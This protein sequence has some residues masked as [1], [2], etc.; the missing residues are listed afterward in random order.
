MKKTN[1]EY[2]NLE[3]PTEKENKNKVNKSCLDIYISLI[4]ESQII[5]FTF[6]NK[7]YYN[8]S[9]KISMFIF[10]IAIILLLNIFFL[11]FTFYI[12]I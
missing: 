11:N 2:D 10:T 12:F 1:P 4:H 8:K 6:V 7:D 3:T 9:I 5:L